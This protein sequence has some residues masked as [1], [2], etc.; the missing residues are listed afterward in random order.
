MS[1]V[2]VGEQA[3]NRDF[4]VYAG[5]QSDKRISQTF[6]RAGMDEGHHELDTGHIVL[7]LLEGDQAETDRRILRARLRRVW[8]LYVDFMS[9]FGTFPLSVLLSIVYFVFGWTAAPSVK[10]RFKLSEPVSLGLFREQVREFE[11]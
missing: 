8:R 11:S 3:V 10:R 4:L 6:R 5:T 2:H 9:R 1:Y 7:G